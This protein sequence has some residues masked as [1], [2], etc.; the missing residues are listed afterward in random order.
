MEKMHT[1]L[2]CLN[3]LIRS[4]IEE[5]ERMTQTRESHPTTTLTLLELDVQE[6]IA[7]SALNPFVGAALERL[8]SRRYPAPQE[9]L[10][11]P[12]QI[13]KMQ[14]WQSLIQRQLR[15]LDF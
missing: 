14:R 2:L 7:F 15:T 5:L 9:G 8:L 12:L 1:S 6:E 11:L 4:L 13:D 3:A 10:N